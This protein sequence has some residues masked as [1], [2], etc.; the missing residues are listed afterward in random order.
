LEAALFS[1][2][3]DEAS[4]QRHTTRHKTTPDQY[5]RACVPDRATVDSGPTAL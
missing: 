4:L 1:L 2:S 5:A 3:K